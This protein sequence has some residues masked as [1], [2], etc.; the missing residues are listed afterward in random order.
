[1]QYSYF[2]PSGIPLGLHDRIK[3]ILSS[4]QPEGF[5]IVVWWVL[6]VFSNP[7]VGSLMKTILFALLIGG[8][9]LLLSQGAIAEP[10]V[11]L[12]SL[13]MRSGPGFEDGLVGIVRKNTQLD[14][15]KCENGWCAAVW[16]KRHGYVV[17]AYVG[18]DN[19]RM[20]II[21]VISAAQAKI[22]SCNR[23]LTEFTNVV[24]ESEK[25]NG[26]FE[27]LN[28]LNSGGASVEM[29]DD[30]VALA[31]KLNKLINDNAGAEA[32]GGFLDKNKN[33]TGA[34]IDALPKAVRDDFNKSLAI[35]RRVKREGNG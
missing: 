22:R 14:V 6:A 35:I 8:C 1:V 24:A 18:Q 29:A 2:F 26:C 7:M 32:I 3:W 10:L 17:Q 11:A 19:D 28:S 30:V 12:R 9:T 15:H 13:E 23:D 31:I 5:H 33:V 20:P 4:L 16:G 27:T 25:I 21:P 34:A